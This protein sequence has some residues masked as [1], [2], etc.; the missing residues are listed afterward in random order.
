MSDCQSIS[1]PF[2]SLP[3]NSIKL[4]DSP[5]FKKLDKVENR[6]DICAYLSY[7]E[8]KRFSNISDH[9]PENVYYMSFPRNKKVYLKLLTVCEWS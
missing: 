7:S 4:S 9:K 2:L 3:I 8:Q 5:E 6:F 1:I